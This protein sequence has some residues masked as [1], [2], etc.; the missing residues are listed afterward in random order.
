MVLA[1]FP[2]PRQGTVPSKEKAPHKQALL[3]TE[4]PEQLRTPEKQEKVYAPCWVA[5]NRKHS[6]RIHCSS[7]WEGSCHSCTALYWAR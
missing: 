5:G 6:T 7:H 4:E 3:A 1:S 2:H